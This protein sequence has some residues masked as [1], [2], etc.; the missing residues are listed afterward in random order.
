MFVL[1][2]I[3]KFCI[4]VNFEPLVDHGFYKSLTIGYYHCSANR[5]IWFI[6]VISWSGKL[7]IAIINHGLKRFPIVN[8][9]SVT[10]GD[11]PLIPG[12]T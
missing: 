4:T 10:G 8:C 1:T 5:S 6:P 9:G 12:S 11:F 7:R 3:T 2:E